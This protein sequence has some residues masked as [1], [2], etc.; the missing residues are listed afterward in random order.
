ME[1][2]LYIYKKKEN[3]KMKLRLY[4]I[5][6]TLV[7]FSAPYAQHNDAYAKR[8]L[9]NAVKDTKPNHINTN[10]EDKELFYVGTFDED[11]GIITGETPQFLARASEY[12][13]KEC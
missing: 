3:N 9:E 11:T 4:A 8:A 2:S 13:K 1:E 10:P 12:V 6:D 5:K 7:G